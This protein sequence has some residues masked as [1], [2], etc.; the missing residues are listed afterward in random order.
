[1]FRHSEELA[2]STFRL[3]SSSTAELAYF[4]SQEDHTI[5]RTRPR[6]ALVYT[7]I[8]NGVWVE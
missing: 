4:N 3:V 2:A 6:A 1:M 7:F 5:L 8:E